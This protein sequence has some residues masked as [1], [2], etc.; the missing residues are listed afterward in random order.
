MHKKTIIFIA[1]SLM[2]VIVLNLTVNEGKIK[3]KYLCI[4]AKAPNP[5]MRSVKKVLK[6][7]GSGSLDKYNSK[8]KYTNHAITI[9]MRGT[10]VQILVVTGRALKPCQL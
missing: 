5:Y 1:A 3:F 2:E 6:K 8:C 7:L 4:E 9:T 10:W